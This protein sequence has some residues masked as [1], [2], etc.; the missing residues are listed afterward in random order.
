MFRAF[1]L[2]NSYLVKIAAERSCFSLFCVCFAGTYFRENRV[3]RYTLPLLVCVCLCV[4]FFFCFFFQDYGR[5][6]GFEDRDLAVLAAGVQLRQVQ[7]GQLS[8]GLP[9]PPCQG[10][11]QVVPGGEMRGGRPLPQRGER[12]RGGVL[13]IVRVDGFTEHEGGRV[14]GAV[15]GGVRGC[16]GRAVVLTATKRGRSGDGDSNV[17]RQ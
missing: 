4:C 15:W 2:P 10:V 12:R 7:R 14:L 5:V 13:C 8:R 9:R 11:R 17:L 6:D 1:A 3:C 16:C